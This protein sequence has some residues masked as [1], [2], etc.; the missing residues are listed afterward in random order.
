MINSFIVDKKS[1]TADWGLLDILRAV[2]IWLSRV[3][4]L[5]IVLS[6]WVGVWVGLGEIYRCCKKIVLQKSHFLELE[7]VDRSLYCRCGW[8]GRS[9]GEISVLLKI[10]PDT[11]LSYVFSFGKK[12]TPSPLSQSSET[13]FIFTHRHHAWWIEWRNILGWCIYLYSRKKDVSSVMYCSRL[14]VD[15]I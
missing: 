11:L 5:I 13:N 12:A 4:R 9:E 10:S 2:C 14:W 15:T 3:C 8:V 7:S 6:G 1:T